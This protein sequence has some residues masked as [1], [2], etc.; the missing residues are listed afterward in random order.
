[1][2]VQVQTECASLH[3]SQYVS[4]CASVVD[5]RWWGQPAYRLYQQAVSKVHLAE[6]QGKYTGRLQ[7]AADKAKRTWNFHHLSKAGLGAEQTCRQESA[8]HAPEVAIANAKAG[9]EAE[10]AVVSHLITPAPPETPAFSADAASAQMHALM[11]NATAELEEEMA[12]MAAD[13]KAT[14]LRDQAMASLSNL[15]SR[16]RQ[17]EQAYDNDFPGNNAAA[18]LDSQI[19]AANASE[20]FDN[21]IVIDEAADDESTQGMVA[22]LE[23]NT[24]T[25]N[26]DSAKLLAQ[27]LLGLKIANTGWDPD[28]DETVTRDQYVANVA[29]ELYATFA[30]FTSQIQDLAVI[31]RQ[32]RTETEEHVGNVEAAAGRLVAI[33]NELQVPELVDE[34]DADVQ[35]ELS[36]QMNQ[37]RVLKSAVNNETVRSQGVFDAAK[38]DEDG[39]TTRFEALK[40]LVMNVKQTKDRFSKA[41]AKADKAAQQLEK[42]KQAMETAKAAMGSLTPSVQ[43]SFEDQIRILETAA[44]PAEQPYEERRLGDTK[45]LPL[46]SLHLDTPEGKAKKARAQKEDAKEVVRAALGLNWN[47]SL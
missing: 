27:K 8:S 20:A 40:E 1:M 21:A 31:K 24:I 18:L 30:A 3:G 4:C 42:M 16:W 5:K 19:A 32:M 2:G 44:N 6:S 34:L 26:E 25:A 46:P 22:A 38:A 17:L 37:T 29:S 23:G 41:S 35:T 9:A 7:A 39:V 14:T 15:Q 36:R 13:H 12:A 45:D 33:E 47:D 43:A 11:A 10:P 28:A